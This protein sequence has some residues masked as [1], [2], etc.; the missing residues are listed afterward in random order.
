M[1]GPAQARG[2]AAGRAGARWPFD[3]SNVRSQRIATIRS[4]NLIDEP[5]GALPRF[6]RVIGVP[7]SVLDAD[8]A[9]P[10][11]DCAMRDEAIRAVARASRDAR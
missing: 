11:P 5:T 6:R 7:V 1:T 9:S 10:H 4:S 3:A 2:D 8:R